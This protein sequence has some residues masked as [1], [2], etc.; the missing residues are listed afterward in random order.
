MQRC[1]NKVNGNIAWFNSVGK[2]ADGTAI[3]ADS[4]VKDEVAIAISLE[5]RLSILKGELWYDILYGLPLLDKAK[6][7]VELDITV[8]T[9]VE[10]HPEVEN[11]EEF[12]SE[13]KEHKYSCKLIINTK[14]GQLSIDI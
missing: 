1:R 5:E 4:F 14:L 2:N 12:V 11:I 7:K 6:T 13:V 10:N 9:I 3:K 8:A